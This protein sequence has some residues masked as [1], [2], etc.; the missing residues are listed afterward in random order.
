MLVHSM[1]D[2]RENLVQ[3]LGAFQLPPNFRGRSAVYVQLWWLVQSL[4]FHTSPQFLYGWRR[5]LLKLFGARVGQGV[6]LRPS[7]VVTYPWNVS[8]G[9][10]SW[11]G[12]NVT[13][14]SLAAVSIGSNT[15]VSQGCYLCAASHDYQDASFPIYGEPI[16]LE[17]EVWLCARAFVHP[18]V[19]IGRGAVVAA[20]SVVTKDVAPLTI[21]AGMPAKPVR[22]RHA[23]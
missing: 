12:D 6:M 20:C 23:C 14:Y 9:A 4:L 13:I 17:P 1:T 7:V 21:V 2:D 18:G 15:V 5:W 8:I 22:S 19:T 3:N 16:N 11:I 10:S